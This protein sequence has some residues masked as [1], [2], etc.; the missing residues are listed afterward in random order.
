M[1]EQT[2][3][4]G[5]LITKP[6]PQKAAAIPFSQQAGFMPTTFDE[7]YR[8]AQML[9]TSD[10]VPKDYREKP[11]NIMV[12]LQMGVELGLKP[13]QALQG[14]AVIN[15]KPGLYGDAFWAL[16]QSSPLVEDIVEQ[17]D[18]TTKTYTCSIKRKGR[19]TPYV[20]SFGE[21]DAKQAG[22]LGKSGPWTTT[23][24]RMKQWR[25]R[26]FAARDAVPEALKGFDVVDNL[27]DLEP[28]P[29]DRTAPANTAVAAL[30]ESIAKQR[31]ATPDPA[32]DKPN[33][34]AIELLIADWM[35]AIETAD[36]LDALADVVM[37][38][39]RAL[40]GK[41]TPDQ[42]ERLKTAMRAA[43][44]LLKNPTT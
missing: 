27:M 24:R 1:T 22:L 10:L 35:S 39:E 6:A 34:G 16:V 7:A 11:A 2:I 20:Q 5:A 30:N 40:S 31:A 9:S 8:F 32:V 41:T 29:G 25:A 26:S 44:T 12:A 42:N 37:R 28:L 17:W 3:E 15:G 13:M 21:A 14:V 43:E 23:P 18:E 36:S 19:S 4:T 38:C 33:P